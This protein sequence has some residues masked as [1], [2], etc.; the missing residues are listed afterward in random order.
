MGIRQ[1]ARRFRSS[2]NTSRTRS[3]SKKSKT[4]PSFVC[5]LPLRTTPA[6]E[7]A[8][9][10]QLEMSRQIYNACLGESLRVL[11]LMR[12][13][14]DWQQAR[15]MPKGKERTARF[16]AVID[17]F[18]FRQSAL[19]R[20]AIACKN[21]CA[22]GNHL[23]PH[24]AQ[25]VAKRAFGA[26]RQYAVGKRRRPRFKGHRGLHSIEGKSNDT[27]IRWKGGRGEWKGRSITTMFDPQ[28]R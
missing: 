12:E 7:R 17:R 20:F 13:S 3:M 10:I 1:L 6:D 8:L 19:D 25:A 5:E 15:A 28:D 14:R 21:G 23:G 4:T 27:A 22:I 2:S 9:A 18:D 26:V 11:T 16:R 24:E